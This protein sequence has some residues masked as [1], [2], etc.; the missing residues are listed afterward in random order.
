MKG[1]R[2][3]PTRIN[4][5]PSVRIRV[6]QN[7]DPR[8]FGAGCLS[9]AHVSRIEGLLSEVMNDLQAMADFKYNLRYFPR[10]KVSLFIGGYFKT[11]PGPDVDLS[12]EYDHF[13]DVV[14]QYNWVNP[15]YPAQRRF[16]LCNVTLLGVEASEEMPD[17]GKVTKVNSFFCDCHRFHRPCLSA[18]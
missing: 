5:Y 7:P 1:N 8:L 18:L 13:M 9:T 4:L 2:T 10:N 3:V 14:Q 6:T 17:A 11:D 15:H 16:H 12:G